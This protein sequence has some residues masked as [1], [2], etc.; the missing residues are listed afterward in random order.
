M[1]LCVNCIYHSAAGR[2]ITKKVR[3]ECVTMHITHLCTHPENTTT[4]FV[5]GEQTFDSCY[6]WNYFDEC[7][8][9]DDGKTVEPDEP[10]VDDEPVIDDDNEDVTPPSGDD[11]T[12]I[13]EP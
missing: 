13:T 1:G 2:D 4:D 11:D 6:K 5:T 3:G 9:F 12:E 7:P 8:K 10:I